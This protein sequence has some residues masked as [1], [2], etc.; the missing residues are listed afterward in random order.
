LPVPGYESQ[1]EVSDHGRVRSVERK[2]WFTN[3]WNQRIQRTVPPKIRKPSTNKNGGHQYV[4]LHPGR[5]FKFVH[6]LVLEAFDRSRP[7]GTQCRH[8]DGDPTNNRLDN[9]AWGTP[10]EN[11][12]DAVRHGTNYHARKTYCKRGHEFTTENTY[13]RPDGK[14]R[15]CWACMRKYSKENG[16]RHQ[17]DYRARRAHQ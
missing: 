1:Y 17:R 10:S 9:L 8:L 11:T 6:A 5:V 16:A 14:G 7:E 12:L 3:R 15:S 13:I 2:V 4:T